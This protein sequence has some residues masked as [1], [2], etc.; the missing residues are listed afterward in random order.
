MP[1]QTKIYFI[2]AL[3]PLHVGA[4]RGVRFIDLPVMR[5]KVTGWPVVPGS[6][7]KGVVADHHNATDKA[8]QN[9]AM[10]RA[11]FG[12]ADT[13]VATEGMPNAGSLVFT[14]ARLICFPVRSLYGTFAWIT[15]PLALKRF[16]R[17]LEAANQTADVLSMPEDPTDNGIFLKEKFSSALVQDGMVFL[18]DHDFNP[19]ENETTAQWAEKLA[20]WIFKED[21]NW[22]MEFMRRFAIISDEAF[23]FFCETG[24]EVIP[25]VRI[26]EETKTVQEGALWYE[27]SLPTETLLAGLVWCD[28][29]FGNEDVTRDGLM[30]HFCREEIRLQMGGKATIGK[31][32]VRLIF[33]E[34]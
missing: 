32:R 33:G 34:E 23:D 13:G 2:H 21:E 16:Y 7:V 27:E 25:R 22:K 1:E 3:T 17:D 30:E 15:S 24:T 18:E 19:E 11:A 12:R 28:R 20:G 5:E 31:G 9:D 10:L 6:S 26:K 14:D 8:R 4:G 29:V